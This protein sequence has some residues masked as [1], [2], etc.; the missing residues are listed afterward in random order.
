MM[1]SVLERFW[2][3]VKVLDPDDCW[4][5][6][7]SVRDSGYGQF[8]VG[9]SAVSRQKHINAHALAWILFHKVDIPPGLETD[10][11]CRNRMCVNPHHLEVVTK[12]VN[13]LRGDSPMAKQAR[14]THCIAGHSLTPDNVYWFG[15]NKTHRQCRACKRR[16]DGEW[17]NRRRAA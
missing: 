9:K 12:K 14:Q 10:H 17:R 5:W 1:A 2:S 11:L 3:K 4:P 16:R 8:N 6:L 13:I 15:K 7:A